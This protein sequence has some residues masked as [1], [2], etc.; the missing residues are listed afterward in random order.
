MKR[1]A[2][3]EMVCRFRKF[4]DMWR[5][6]AQDGAGQCK[7]LQERADKCMDEK[8]VEGMREFMFQHAGAYSVVQ[9][10]EGRAAA[11]HKSAHMCMELL[12]R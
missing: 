12:E 6:Q 5:K 3:I 10:R 2:I 4:R 1:R 8:N 7:Y 11:Y 9:N